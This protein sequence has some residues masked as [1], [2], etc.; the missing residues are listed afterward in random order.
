MDP[1]VHDTNPARIVF[2][3][4][5]VA[6]LGDE[7]ERLGCSRTLVVCTPGRTAMAEELSASL[8]DKRVAVCAEA[9]MHVPLENAEIGREAARAHQADSVVSI[10]GGSAIGLGKAIALECDIPLI[11]VV[12]TYSGS[13]MT[14]AC[15][16]VEG[17]RKIQYA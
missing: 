5:K 9:R 14:A 10:G 16:M 2:G 15:G 3:A 7:V 8:G 12:T 17:G 11:C 1:F 13:E 4:G 6:A